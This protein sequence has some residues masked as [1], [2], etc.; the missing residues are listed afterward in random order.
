MG[1]KSSRVGLDQITHLFSTS[2]DL[3]LTEIGQFC[4]TEVSLICKLEANSL[5]YEEKRQYEHKVNTPCDI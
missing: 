5:F 2:K 3:C 4:N 1:T